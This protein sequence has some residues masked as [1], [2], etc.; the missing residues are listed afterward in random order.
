MNLIIYLITW[1]G[2]EG[3][4][5]SG[6][7]WTFPQPFISICRK[8]D[9]LFIL[10]LL[11]Q[12]IL[13][14]HNRSKKISYSIRLFSISYIIILFFS[15]IV[16][17]VSPFILAEYFIRYGK[18]LIIFIYSV[19]FIELNKK[20][21]L[22][23]MG[24]LRLFFQLQFFINGLWFL[25]IRLIPNGDY[26][27]ADWA[28]GTFGNPFYTSLFTAIF[29]SGCFYQLL[30]GQGVSKGK[31][32]NFIYVLLCIIQL[33]WSDTKHLFFVIPSILFFQLFLLNIL[34]KRK[35]IFLIILGLL[36]SYNFTNT[37]LFYYLSDNF[38]T[39][40][41]LLL[42]SPKTMAYYH[43]FITIPKE[44][45]FAGLGAG[46]GKG[47]SFIGMEDNSV[48]TNKYF[49]KYNIESLRVG[50]TIMTVPFTGI[51]TIQSELGY[52]GF[53]FFMIMFFASFRSMYY[54]N[55]YNHIYKYGYYFSK[56]DF[57]AFFCLLLFVT[58]NIFADLLQHTAFPVLVWFFIALYYL[59]NRKPS[60]KISN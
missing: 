30:I 9:E 16:N 8:V 4:F 11:F 35:K 57:V 22:Y 10:L 58:E 56:I 38:N 14:F 50:N 29:L 37:S 26:S 13:N 41:R 45:P 42:S 34:N 54:N 53:G 1:Y 33:I 17:Q 48:I 46:P 44:V 60:F 25:G 27:N 21:I 5:T 12:I 32:I 20:Q 6:K 2:F 18:G 7:Y 40:K 51:N 49:M 36:L 52:I 28:I 31:I 43:S 19:M 47:G 15:C 24:H 3:I 55:K 23:F 39:G 59:N